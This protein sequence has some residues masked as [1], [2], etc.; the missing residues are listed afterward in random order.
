MPDKLRVSGLLKYDTF[1]LYRDKDRRLIL[2]F[3]QTVLETKQRSRLKP[4]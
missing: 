4:V 2:P 1:V 3:T